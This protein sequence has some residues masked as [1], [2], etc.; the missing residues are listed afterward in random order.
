MLS[1]H[2]C[3]WVRTKQWS[4]RRPVLRLALLILCITVLAGCDRKPKTP[5][6]ELAYLKELCSGIWNRYGPSREQDIEELRPFLKSTDP[7]VRLEA[8][9]MLYVLKDRSGYDVLLEILKGP[10]DLLSHRAA[11]ILAKY[12][13][14]RAGDAI[15]SQYRKTKSLE[16]WGPLRTLRVEGMLSILHEFLKER[17]YPDSIEGLAIIDTQY[18][19]GLFRSIADN[20]EATPRQRAAAIF[21][22]AMGGNPADLERLIAVATNAREA[23]PGNHE[24]LY[25]AQRRAVQYLTYFRGE[26]VVKVFEGMLS[27]TDKEPVNGIALVYLR[28]RYPQN[29]LSREILK[30]GI[31]P[32]G[33]HIVGDYTLNLQLIRLSGDP[34]LIALGHETDYNVSRKELD[35]QTGWSNAWIGEYYLPDWEGDTYPAL[36]PSPAT[37]QPANPSVSTSAWVILASIITTIAGWLHFSTKRRSERG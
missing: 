6:E 22:L 21:G 11:R 33:A 13:E 23:L 20:N 1:P 34:A 12:R 17:M 35:G 9:E 31:Q 26:R 14:R 5:E 8:A 25:L 30:K 10:N 3:L 18:N 7:T 19:Q 32:G 27:Y 15:L 2:L 29:R 36:S 37:V 24:D 16:F 4:H 28:Y